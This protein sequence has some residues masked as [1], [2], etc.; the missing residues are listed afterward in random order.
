MPLASPDEE[1]SRAGEDGAVE[2]AE[3]GTGDEERHEEGEGAEHLVREGHG[4]RLG[5]QDFFGVQHHEVRHV[6][7]HV[8][9]R[10]QRH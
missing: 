8:D 4:D 6:G 3:G 10:H 1:E 9:Y 7:H 2:R 5:G